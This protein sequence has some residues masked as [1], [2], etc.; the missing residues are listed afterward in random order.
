MLSNLKIP[1]KTRTQSLQFD[2]APR[3]GE[4]LVSRRVPDYFLVRASSPQGDPSDHLTI[5]CE[6]IVNYMMDITCHLIAIFFH[7]YMFSPF[8]L[9]PFSRP[10]PPLCAS[11]PF[12]PLLTPSACCCLHTHMLP[13]VIAHS[14][15]YGLAT[16]KEKLCRIQDPNA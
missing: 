16:N 7:L 13:D 9:R 1:L 6:M 2:P 12:L 14:Y 8:S 10:T 4:P 11:C 3:A 15:T 5:F